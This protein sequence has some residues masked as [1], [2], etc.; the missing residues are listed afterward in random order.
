M[1]KQLWIRDRGCSFP[2]CNAPSFWCDSHHLWHWV[3]GGPTATSNAALLCGRH[4][5]VVHHQRLHGT[6][7][8]QGVAWNRSPGS[9][10]RWLASEHRERLRQPA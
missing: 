4:H 5:T 10:D 8:P 9:Y 6:V 3:D 7:T 1:T 2:G